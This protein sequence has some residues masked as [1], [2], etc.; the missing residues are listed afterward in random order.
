MPSIN[1]VTIKCCLFPPSV[2]TENIAMDISKTPRKQNQKC[3]SVWPDARRVLPLVPDS[4]NIIGLTL[5]QNVS[6]MCYIH[7]RHAFHS[8]TV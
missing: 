5:A 8:D 2:I 3:Q 1:T 6:W 4:H 7:V